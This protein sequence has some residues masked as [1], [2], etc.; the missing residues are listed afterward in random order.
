MAT[1]AYDQR[2]SRMVMVRSRGTLTGVLLMI[3]GVW[4]ALVPFIGHS[5]SYGFS[6]DNTW[7][8]TA[9]RGWLEVLPGA[10]TFIGGLLITVSAHRASAMIGAWLAAAGGAWFVLGTVITPWWSAGNIGVPLGSTNVIVWERI[11]MF[12]GLGVLIVFLAAVALGR[13]SVVAVRD[14][15]KQTV[16]TDPGSGTVRV[17]QDRPVETVGDEPLGDETQPAATTQTTA[18][19]QPVSAAQPVATEPAPATDAPMGSRDAT[20]ASRRQVVDVTDEPETAATGSTPPG[21]TT[22]S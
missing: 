8:W 21:G 14:I 3:L 9:A 16:V 17:V 12:D 20:A 10:A 18:V 7:T 1:H 22:S 5:F 19:T 4:G 11:G 6:P 13:I 15:E 2:P